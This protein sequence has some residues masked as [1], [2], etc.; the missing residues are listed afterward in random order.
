MAKRGKVRGGNATPARQRYKAEGRREK[1]KT[2]RAE[3]QARIEA[4]HKAKKEV[5]EL[6]E[7]DDQS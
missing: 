3:R 6:I 5:V 1:N 2:K 4:K 7:K